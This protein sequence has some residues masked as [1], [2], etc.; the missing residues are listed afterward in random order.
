MNVEGIQRIS[1]FMSHTRGEQ[2][3]RLAA[4][5]LNRFKGLLPRFRR[6]MED[7]RD[8]GAAG[9]L[10]IERSRIQAQK[11]WSRIMHFELMSHDT[12]STGAVKI[13]NLLPIEFWNEIGDLLA[14][15]IGFQPQKTRNRLVEIK[16][17]PVLIH[18]QDSVLNSVEQRLQKAPLAR[19]PLNDVLQA[20]PVE[21]R[22][23]AE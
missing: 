13:G 5:A 16:N 9:R 4:L 3:E 17:S 15:D 12:T 6:V 10:A 1:D 18:H 20:L 7:E 2:R 14:L 23:A 8:T 21:A 22:N 11:S 19:K